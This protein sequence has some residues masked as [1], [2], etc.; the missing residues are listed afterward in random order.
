MHIILFPLSDIVFNVFRRLVQIH[1]V[2]D[3]S[4]VEAGLPCKINILFSR[5]MRYPSLQTTD[6]GTQTLMQHW[7]GFSRHP[8]F[9]CLKT[10]RFK[11]D[12]VF[13]NTMKI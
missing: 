2:T 5:I 8:T 12:G 7:I 1:L 11:A 4:V 13:I 3:D 9:V 10:L 6:D